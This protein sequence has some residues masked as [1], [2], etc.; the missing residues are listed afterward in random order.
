MS[1]APVDPSMRNGRSAF[2][3]FV[4]VTALGLAAA[5]CLLW[6]G[7][8]SIHQDEYLPLFPITWF[9]KQPS[10]LSSDIHPYTREMF[11]RV[12]P[13]LSYPYLGA[14]KA[15]AYLA[16]GLPTTPGAYRILQLAL[17]GVLFVVVLRACWRLSGRS[18]L[19]CAVCIVLLLADTGLVILG[20]LDEG[21]QVPSLFFGT[22][23]F[24]CLYSLVESPRVWKIL[25]IA[26]VV[27]VGEL[28]RVNFLWFVGAG[29]AGCV[30]AALV[31]PLW[32]SLG[33]VTVAVLGCA[34][35]L[36]GAARVLPNYP[37]MVWRGMQQSIPTFDVSALWRHWLVLFPQLDPYSAYHRY[38]DTSATAHA[39]SYAA[40]RWA[41]MALY[42]AIVATCALWG[43][44]LA[45]RRRELAR[46]ML[47]L[48]A[49]MSALLFVIVKTNESWSAH[50]IF[51]IKP[52]A[53]VGMGL[54]A[55]QAAAA[56]GV[57][58]ALA[59]FVILLAL[60]S[61]WVGALAYRDMV[62]APRIYGVYDVGRNQLEAWQAAA[63]TP[64]TAVYALDWGVF[65]PGVL[66]SPA[67]Q[68][69]EAPPIQTLEQ[70][71]HLDAA[72]AGR[73]MALLFH[74]KGSMRWLLDSTNGRE[75]F[76]IADV[77]TFDRH[78]G[79]PWTLVVMNLSKVEPAAWIPPRDTAELVTNGDF[80]DGTLGWRYEE[81]EKLPN[82]AE[83]S[84]LR[85]EIDGSTRPCVHLEHRSD[86][87]SRVV[88][89]VTIPPRTV[90]VV[91]AWARADGVGAA[92]KGVHLVL[93]NHGHVGSAE[94]RGTTDWQQLR[95][96][97]I[98]PQ[99]TAR[100]IRLA[101]RVG[102]WGDLNTGSA[103]FAAVSVRP[104]AT[105]DASVPVYLLGTEP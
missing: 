62:A 82:G 83:L 33:V 47:F 50:H 29:L 77:Q 85:C 71:R 64:V 66:N 10:A 42:V 22:L 75:R 25:P 92:S 19:A 70:L 23:L 46:P 95:F 56:P 24:L 31:G 26:I 34:L 65:Y 79:E 102:T 3:P 1:D 7:M 20:I 9:T 52:F 21:N 69:W 101:A 14:V 5:G 18:R 12:F 2:W 91:S 35:G 36:A 16:L 41:W 87:D 57:R 90:A 38:V 11:G 48:A 13:V 103:W 96:S 89:E 27:F 97:L 54:L 43:L 32:R 8:P 94:L 61:G 6:P 60:G 104:V 84:V 51:L 68:R 74:T 28:D 40:Y 45:R 88:Q 98:N 81:W 73:D 30:A 39:S 80:A 67:T 55:A 53:Y 37:S 93:L 100:R 44:S 76:G 15:Y 4:G 49:F 63:R 99:E 72:R 17:L 86:A 105:P 58:R 59:A 78:L